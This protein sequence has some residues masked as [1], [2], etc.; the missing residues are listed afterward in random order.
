MDTEMTSRRR[1]LAGMV[2]TGL[3]VLS[4]STVFGK[5]KET[6]D[7]K[8]FVPLFNGKDLQGWH[9]NV[10]KIVHG[11]GGSWKVENGAI[12]GEQDPPGSGNGGILMTDQAYGDFELLLELAP[13]WGIDSG[14]FLR[15]NSRGE[16]FQVY[17]DYHDH[18]NIGWISTET[19]T[20]QKRMIIRPFNIFGKMNNQG[21]LT[22]FTTKPD[23]R[24]IAWKPDYL[25]YSA[26]PEYWL[27]TWKV[28]KWNTLRIR[29]VGEYPHITT[30]INNTKL[31][32]FDGSSCPQPN[33]DK[34]KILQTLSRKGS[35]AFQ[36]HGGKQMWAEGAKCRWRN[37]RIKNL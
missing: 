24:E 7:E 20:G 8:G 30:W 9:T 23:E 35:I 11:N 32:E 4:H 28:G 10:Q 34:D 31:A 13:D 26:E 1:F 5:T 29:C 3:G 12:T 6:A 27:S 36:V 19:P 16:C 15:T 18:G 22:G 33:Y 14:V 2:G 17:V 37:I 25:V 21:T